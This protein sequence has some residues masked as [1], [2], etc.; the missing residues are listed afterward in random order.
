MTPRCPKWLPSVQ[1][2]SPAYAPSGSLNSQVVNTPG[3]FDSPVM[4]LRELFNIFSFATP[5][6]IYHQESWLTGDEYTGESRL[7]GGEYTGKSIT[8]T[9]NS[10]NIRLDSKSSPG[11]YKGTRKSCL[12]KKPESK[13]LV[14]LSL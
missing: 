8:N 11:M 10:T 1:N 3:S 7:P 6:C 14:T 5:W 9:N 2:D 13:N 4:N 12:M